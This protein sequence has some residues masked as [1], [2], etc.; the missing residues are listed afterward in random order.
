[1]MVFVRHA[2]IFLGLSIAQFSLVNIVFGANGFIIPNILLAVT[3]LWV[4]RHGFTETWWR[5]MI[6]GCVS[7]FISAGSVGITSLLLVWFA[8]GTSFLSRRFLVEHSG[9][10][11]LTATILMG[12]FSITYTWFE[13]WFL[14]WK[15]LSFGALSWSN[16]WLVA[17]FWSLSMAILINGGT[18]L[19]LL[20]TLKRFSRQFFSDAGAPLMGS[21]SR[22]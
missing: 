6:L 8:Y 20:F 2:S 5:A 12:L 10:G 13:G 21:F 19:I 7:D 22:I 15:Y 4:M 9:E 16:P 1:M 17:W 3:M 11:V 14:T 18:F